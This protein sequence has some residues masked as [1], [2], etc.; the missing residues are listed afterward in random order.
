LLFISHLHF[1][2]SPT[3]LGR[4][5]VL[6]AAGSTS[7]LP[8]TYLLPYFLHSF[9]CIPFCNPLFIRYLPIRNRV[10]MRAL[11]IFAL[12]AACLQSQFQVP[13]P[14]L[15]P[16]S[17]L[18]PQSHTNRIKIYRLGSDVSD[19]TST[20]YR[21]HNRLFPTYRHLR[22]PR[23]ETRSLLVCPHQLHYLY[24]R[25]RPPRRRHIPAL[26]THSSQRWGPLV[27]H[28]RLVGLLLH[29]FWD[30]VGDERRSDVHHVSGFFVQQC[31][32]RFTRLG[33]NRKANFVLQRLHSRLVWRRTISSLPTA[34]KSSYK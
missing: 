24:P 28:V 30:W 29:R 14:Y 27:P 5:R 11:S 18:T 3:Y 25:R 16:Y 17:V 12:G 31:V 34:I 7:N 26:H 21:L 2:P 20:P 22:R 4:Y 33:R 6:P 19:L 10:A 32:S 13:T 9:L 15:T 1:S 8:L 23:R